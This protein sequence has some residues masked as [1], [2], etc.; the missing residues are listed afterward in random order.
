M[1]IVPTNY[2]LQREQYTQPFVAGGSY[3]FDIQR[4][5]DLRT[6]YFEVEGT[7][8]LSVAATA[9]KGFAPAQLIDKISFYADGAKTFQ[10]VTGYT[11]LFADFERA[12]SRDYTLPGITAAT[13]NVRAVFRMDMVNAGGPR[14]KDSAIHTQQPFMSLLQA[15]VEFGDPANMFDGGTVSTSDLTIKVYSDETQELTQKGMY[16]TRLLKRLSLQTYKVDSNNTNA[17]I[18]ISVGQAFRGVKLIALDENNE[19]SNVLINNVKIQSGV[20][21]RLNLTWDQ[22]RSAN[23]TNYRIALGDMP[24]GVAFA[25]L[26]PTGSVLSLYDLT[27][28]SECDLVLN[29]TKPAGGSGTVYAQPIHFY[30]IPQP[31]GYG[32][33]A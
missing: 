33:A 7:V 17:T 6:L 10:D 24:D 31:Q 26:S 1:A 5:Y 20:D 9:L 2:P 18:K 15:R 29:V 28:K 12:M 19:P 27:N 25:D 13:H 23:E 4:G 32:N 14:P 22:L 21:V 11:L 16:E 3:T 30:E 8:T